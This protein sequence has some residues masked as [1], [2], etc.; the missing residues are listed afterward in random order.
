M[1]KIKVIPSNEKIKLKEGVELESDPKK[2]Y[3]NIR[4]LK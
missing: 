4:D 1:G 2:G 3:K